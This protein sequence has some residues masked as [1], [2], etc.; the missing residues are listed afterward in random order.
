[1][2]GFLYNLLAFPLWAQAFYDLLATPPSIGYFLQQ[3]FVG[4]VFPALADYSYATA[5]QPGARHAPLHFVS[6]K[7]F[8]P[9]VRERIYEALNIPVLVI[10]DHDPYVDFDTLEPFVN[11]HANWYSSR[12]TPS[13]GLPHFEHLPTRRRRWTISGR[14]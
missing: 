10:Y 11:A 3:N 7:L 14:R 4:P 8:T 9:H 12:I 5:H 1:M 2:G 6:G 13:R